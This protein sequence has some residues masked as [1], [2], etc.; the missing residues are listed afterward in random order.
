[1]LTDK[2]DSECVFSHVDPKDECIHRN[3]LI[4]TFIYIQHVYNSG[5]LHGTRGRR[6]ESHQY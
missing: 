3:M 2:L 6:R 5:L 4:C 1:M